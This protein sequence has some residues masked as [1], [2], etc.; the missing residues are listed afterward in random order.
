MQAFASVCNDNGVMIRRYKN[1]ASL[2]I[3]HFL[4]FI[5][6]HISQLFIYDVLASISNDAFV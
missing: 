2:H 4:H 5:L 6:M 1:D 3:M